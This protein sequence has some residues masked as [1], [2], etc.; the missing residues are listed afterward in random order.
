MPGERE[1]EI[2]Q[3][4]LELL[5]DLCSKGEVQDDN[6]LDF[7]Y[8][9]RDLARQPYADTGQPRHNFPLT[10]AFCKNLCICVN[11]CLCVRVRTCVCIHIYIQINCSS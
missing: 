9:F 10:F 5:S 11:V 4:A 3:K 6:C 8:Y 1:D 7:I 2:C